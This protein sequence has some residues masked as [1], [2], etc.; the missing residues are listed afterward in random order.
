LDRLSLLSVLRCEP[1]RTRS[2]WY[3][4]LPFAAGFVIP[5]KPVAVLAYLHYTV[6]GIMLDALCFLLFYYFYPLFC[7][8]YGAPSIMIFW[9]VSGEC[10][11]KRRISQRN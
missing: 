5:A 2:F 6:D 11:E 3:V 8:L 1:R 10:Y 7:L 4:S 9:P